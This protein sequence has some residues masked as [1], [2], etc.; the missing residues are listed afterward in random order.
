MPKE[1][2]HHGTITIR[3]ERPG[4]KEHPGGMRVTRWN[5]GDPVP[6]GATLHE[7]PSVDLHWNRDAGWV[8][9]SI[10]APR[11]W[12]EGWRAAYD[13][14]PEQHTFQVYSEVLTR[15]ELNHLIRTLRRA[16]DSAYGADE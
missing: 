12:W 8:Q 16:R 3:E 9:L 6:P 14:S 11:D 1:R 10:D 15:H 4:T 7:E 13:G 5:P 2:V